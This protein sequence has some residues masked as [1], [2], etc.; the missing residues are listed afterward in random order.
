MN[1]YKKKGNQVMIKRR[2]VGKISL[3]DLKIKEIEFLEKT[4]ER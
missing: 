1:S 2:S 3:K 4:M